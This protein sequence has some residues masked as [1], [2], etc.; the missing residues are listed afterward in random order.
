M[1][2]P[3]RHRERGIV[4]LGL[5]IALFLAAGFLVLSRANRAP[6]QAAR[7]SLD[8]PALQQAREAL[9]ARA[10]SDANR[11]GSLPCPAPDSNGSALAPP[12]A[13][14]VGWFPWRTLGLP[15]LRDQSG[16]RLWYVL[17]PSLQDSGAINSNAV[18]SLTLDGGS[19]IAALII[20]PGAP[21]AGQSRPS[22][23]PADYLDAKDG[24]PATSN[25]D[26]NDSYFSAQS[27]ENFNDKVL[28]LSTSA[29]FAGVSKRVL[30]EI[31]FAYNTALPGAAPFADIDGDGLS[32]AADIGSFPYNNPAFAI[33][34]PS[35]YAASPPF[36]KW[37][38]S[39]LSNGWFPLVGYNRL[40]KTV[41]LNGQVLSLP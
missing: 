33:D 21:L 17:S 5:M 8:I 3:K 27:S 10:V 11:P 24:N 14:Y 1:L 41:S 18:S 39:L 25:A 13:T 37:Y 19:G 9:L 31:S 34:S 32:D 2:E 35:W 7:D 23:S 6:N 28:V 16:E 40:S 15:D 30:G 20:A 4:L 26:L 29:L 38:D 22:F 36:H 12:C